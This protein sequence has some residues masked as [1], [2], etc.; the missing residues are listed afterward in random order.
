MTTQTFQ[1]AGMTCS[2]CVRFVTEELE[3]I[4]GVTAVAIDLPTGTVTLSGTRSIPTLEL[5]SAL[6]QAGYDLTTPPT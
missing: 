5:Q 4:P 1:V 2:H 6:E 3:P